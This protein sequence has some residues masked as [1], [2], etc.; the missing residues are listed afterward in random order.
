MTCGEIYNKNKRIYN[1][2]AV[3]YINEFLKS[4]GD[5]IH[6]PFE[7]MTFYQRTI[8]EKIDN[9]KFLVYEGF[10][11]KTFYDKFDS[12]IIS[13]TG[14]KVNPAIYSLIRLIQMFGF[15]I[16]LNPNSRANIEINNNA[17]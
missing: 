13:Y 6:R 15:E 7:M 4:T 12:K 17:L 11:E 16:S 3:I 1:K 14:K 8:C 9:D 5:K 10:V 2:H